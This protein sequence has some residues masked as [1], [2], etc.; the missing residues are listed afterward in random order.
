MRRNLPLNQPRGNRALARRW[1][2]LPVRHIGWQ[3]HLV[4]VPRWLLS[5]DQS[6]C[7]N[8]VRSL[9]REFK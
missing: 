5:R 8:S 3:N 1:A 4:V 2:E 7:C 6:K 9:G